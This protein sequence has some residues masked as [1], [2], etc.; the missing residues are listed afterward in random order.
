M[1]GRS[2]PSSGDHIFGRLA[3]SAF[4]VPATGQATIPRP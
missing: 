1:V 3:F 2:P 4:G